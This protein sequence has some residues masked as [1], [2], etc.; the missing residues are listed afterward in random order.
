MKRQGEKAVDD[1]AG[2]L[3]VEVITLEAI[4]PLSK[5]AWAQVDQNSPTNTSNSSTNITRLNGIQKAQPRARFSMTAH[6]GI[7][8][9]EHISVLDDPMHNLGVSSQ[10]S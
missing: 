4:P 3:S 10:E 9:S 5:L 2:T 7:H 1:P 8:I 6:C